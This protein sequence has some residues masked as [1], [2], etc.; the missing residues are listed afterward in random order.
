MVYKIRINSLNFKEAIE[1]LK[2]IGSFCFFGDDFFLSTDKDISKIKF[3]S[4]IIEINSNN[5]KRYTANSKNLEKWCQMKITQQ[6][7]SDYEKT[8]ECQSKLKQLN[9]LMD[10]IEGR[11]TEVE[12][13]V[14]TTNSKK[15]TTK[16]RKSK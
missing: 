13:V 1:K 15:R 9:E 3:I 5:Y 8:E 12:K 6:E 7:L 2:D 10:K 16:K 11:E 4:D 14:R